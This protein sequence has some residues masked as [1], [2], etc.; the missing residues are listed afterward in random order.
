VAK[1]T[2][3]WHNPPPVMVISGNE[4]FLRRQQLSKALTAARVTGR[5][6]EDIEDPE[7]GAVS[8]ILD[9]GFFL[10]EPV[11]VL[12]RNPDKMDMKVVLD[13]SESGSKEICL[14]LY[15]EG[16]IRSN[17]ALGKALEA[18][19]KRFKLTFLKPDKDHLIMDRAIKFVCTESQQRGKQIGTGLAESLVKGVGDDL[20]I[21]YFEV[22]KAATYADAMGSPDVIEPLH[23]RAT[24]ARNKEADIIPISDAMARGSSLRVLREMQKVRERSMVPIP[25]LTSNVCALVGSQA[26]R[27]L[28]AAIIHKQGGDMSEGASRLGVTPY[29][30]R[31]YILPPAQ[32][33]GHRFLKGLIKKCARVEI[34]AKTGHIDP[35]IEL[36]CALVSSCQNLAARG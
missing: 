22:L 14:V 20:G 23:V 11:L 5:R 18:L 26:A 13:H 24:V 16:K 33:W 31:Q 12:V 35:W 6:V 32:L 21:L 4:G 9:A 15:Y 17:S 10:S 1:A 36:E 29:V 27:W 3:G 28:H 7:S 8:A 34:S 25:K 30:Y 2:V 19:P